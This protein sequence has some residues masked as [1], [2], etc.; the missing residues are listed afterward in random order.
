M[1][2]TEYTIEDALEEIGE[3]EDMTQLGVPEKLAFVLRQMC[4]AQGID[5]EREA[6]LFG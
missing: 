3:C 4:L 6:E 5:I 2:K 1:S